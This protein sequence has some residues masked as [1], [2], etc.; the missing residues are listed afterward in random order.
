MS[1]QWMQASRASSPNMGRR[2]ALVVS[3]AALAAASAVAREVPGP[4]LRITGH[5]ADAK[6]IE[7]WAQ[8]YATD[9][10]GARVIA[11]LRG[12][13]S[14]MA[15][16]YTDTADIAFIGRELRLPVENMAFQWVK[17]YEPLVIEVA[18]AGPASTRAA[19]SLGVFVHE[20]HPLARISLP[21]LRSVFEGREQQ[22]PPRWSALGVAGPWAA[23]EI[24]PLSPSL[25]STDALYFRRH[26][27]GNNFKW[28]P[29]LREVAADRSLAQALAANP[30][31]LAFAPLSAA[32]P[33]VR[34]IAVSPAEGAPAVQPDVQ[35]LAA[36][37]YPLARGVHLAI[38]RDPRLPTRPAVAD[39]LRYVLSDEGQRAL[40]V[41]GAYLPLPAKLRAHALEKLA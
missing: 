31:A 34:A 20:S 21:Q 41:D 2:K 38:D 33:G 40:A 6:L 14:A 9:H 3:A 4:A 8:G 5:P 15:G 13:E 12:V 37:R 35:S 29:L 23:Q 24:V 10:P 30:S 27:M 39:F 1:R 17:L 19:A 36:R 11:N 32:A 18:T 25:D 16:I 28:S 22:S 7:L 26:V